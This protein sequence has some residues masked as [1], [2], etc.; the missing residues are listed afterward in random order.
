MNTPIVRR[1]ILYSGVA[2]LA[3]F[4][5]FLLLNGRFRGEWEIS[6]EPEGADTKIQVY[7]GTWDKHARYELVLLDSHC[8]DIIHRSNRRNLHQN[9]RVVNWDDTHLPGLLVFEMRGVTFAVMELGIDVYLSEQSYVERLP[10]GRLTPNDVAL[11]DVR[12]GT[13]TH[14]QREG[15]E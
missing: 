1:S 13:I 3:T 6:I 7:W 5:L 11:I 14:K 2:A 12:K 4:A 9:V 10:D 15:P 8:Q